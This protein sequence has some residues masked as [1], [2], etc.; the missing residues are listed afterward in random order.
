M[1]DEFDS[2]S[3]CKYKCLKKIYLNQRFLLK[4]PS[5]DSFHYK[6]LTATYCSPLTKGEGGAIWCIFIDHD[7]KTTLSLIVDLYIFYFMQ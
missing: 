5:V 3:S 4:T 2:Y 1:N 6:M 7:P